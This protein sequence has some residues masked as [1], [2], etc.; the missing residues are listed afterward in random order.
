[1]L[2]WPSLASLGFAGLPNLPF[3]GIKLSLAFLAFLGLFL[4]PSKMQALRTLAGPD[5]STGFVG[6]LGFLGFLVCFPGFELF[7]ALFLGGLPQGR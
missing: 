7:Q 3:S 4:T 5:V 2:H 1:M 6:F